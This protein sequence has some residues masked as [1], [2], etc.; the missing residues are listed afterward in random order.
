MR[1]YALKNLGLRDPRPPW[2][3]R[4]LSFFI[5]TD[6][7]KDIIVRDIFFQLPSFVLAQLLIAGQISTTCNLILTVIFLRLFHHRP[8]PVPRKLRYVVFKLVA[9]MIF[10]DIDLEGKNIAKVVPNDQLMKEKGEKPADIDSTLQQPKGGED[11]MYMK[12]WQTIAKVLDKLL[13]IVNIISFVIA[14]GYGY[15]IL[16]T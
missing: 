15:T 1:Q 9:P 4:I 12:E 5:V 16:Y 10:F 7:L 2:H 13:F 3:V 14:F 11:Q 6:W 8:S